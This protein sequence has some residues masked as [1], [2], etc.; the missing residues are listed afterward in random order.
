MQ[1][2]R[3]AVQTRSLPP[4]I[5][6]LPPY[7]NLRRFLLNRHRSRTKVRRGWQRWIVLKKKKLN[8]FL[9]FTSVHVSRHRASA[10]LSKLGGKEAIVNRGHRRIHMRG[11]VYASMKYADYR[12][13]VHGSCFSTMRERRTRAL[14]IRHAHLV[15]VH[16]PRLHG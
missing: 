7:Q 15:T 11:I 2:S 1:R 14:I 6:I 4:T 8:L 5:S 16:R 3:F 10:I 13:V 12:G 9:N